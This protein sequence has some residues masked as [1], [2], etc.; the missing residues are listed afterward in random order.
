[1]SVTETSVHEITKV[2]VRSSVMKSE[3]SPKGYLVQAYDFM[4]GDD[5]L[6]TV[7]IYAPDGQRTMPSETGVMFESP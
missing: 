1:M 2:R 4:K 7:T 3:G 6:H 5:V